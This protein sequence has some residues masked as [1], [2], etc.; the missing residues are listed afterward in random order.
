MA[1]GIIRP[2][3]D[4]N[5]VEHFVKGVLGFRKDR[6]IGTAI[7][8][9]VTAEMCISEIG[10]RSTSRNT[11]FRDFRYSTDEKRVELQKQILSEL[12]SYDRIPDDERIRLGKGGAKPLTVK[13]EKQAIIIT[14]LPASGK[15]GVASKIADN[16][17]AY[18]IDSDYAKRKFPEFSKQYGASLVHEESKLITVTDESFNLLDYCITQGYN[19]V[20]PIIG[21]NAEALL[22][23]ANNFKSKGYATHLLLVSLDRKKAVVRAYKRFIKTKRYVPLGLLFDEYGNEPT[24]A[25]YRIKNNKAFKSYGKVSSDVAFGKE[26]IYVESSKISP[27]ILF[28]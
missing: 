11:E 8:S 18:I 24:L 14:G 2:L 20:Y 3:N 15:S 7:D 25:Y 28:K 13:R 19:I 12:I 10:S 27:A 9:I 5:F 26:P 17:G 6:E 21:H 16:Y 22:R 23:Y 4:T 1:I